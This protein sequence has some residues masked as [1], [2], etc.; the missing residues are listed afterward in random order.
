MAANKYYPSIRTLISD[1]AIPNSDW[2]LNENAKQLLD[3]IFYKDLVIVSSQDRSSKKHSL[4]LITNTSVGIGVP[5]IKDMKLVLNSNG[6][7]SGSEF[8]I[9]LFLPLTL[10]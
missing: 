4:K 5:G 9:E 1:S 7:G 8:E 3:N 10:N 2:P 6:L